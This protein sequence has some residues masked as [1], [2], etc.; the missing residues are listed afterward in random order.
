MD[1]HFESLYE[2]W[3]NEVNI[4]NIT[5]N[6]SEMDDNEAIKLLSVLNYE[7]YLLDNENICLLIFKYLNL[8]DL[9]IVSQVSKRWNH[10][11]GHSILWNNM[12]RIHGSKKECL[13]YINRYLN[14]WNK[15]C[16]CLGVGTLSELYLHTQTT[17]KM[18]SKKGELKKIFQ[19]ACLYEAIDIF[20]DCIQYGYPLSFDD[21]C[22]LINPC[23]IKLE[24][25]MNLVE[26]YHLTITERSVL[27]DRASMS[28][29]PYT[30][31]IF[32]TIPAYRA[33]I[34]KTHLM[35]QIFC[36]NITGTNYL[37]DKFSED[38]I[39]IVLHLLTSNF[40]Y[41]TPKIFELCIDSYLVRNDINETIAENIVKAIVN[42][43]IINTTN[44]EKYL[45]P[46]RKRN[47]NVPNKILGW[48]LS[49]VL[50]NSYLQCTET[51]KENIFRLKILLKY[52]DSNFMEAN[53]TVISSMMLDGMDHSVLKLIEK[54]GDKLPIYRLTIMLIERYLSQSSRSPIEIFYGSKC[55]NILGY[56]K[57][58]EGTTFLYQKW[59]KNVETQMKQKYAFNLAICKAI[60][61]IINY[62]I[63][64]AK[65]Y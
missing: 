22:E 6:Y 13:Q 40:Q 56:V 27:L 47:I 53:E 41:I 63:T 48:Y 44:I 54:N 21:L 60:S 52:M 23:T 38:I 4:Y 2:Q 50:A 58:Y 29:S 7:E 62:I 39:D 49:K 42:S 31:D 30:V 35:N 25:L 61:T 45:L 12:F 65:S 32:R 15:I 33:P 36:G 11:A 34:T 37:I 9:M 17:L 16:S 55:R 18:K 43:S 19:L 57:K 5:N 1:Y 26:C 20:I 64:I 14:Q 28:K 10:I 8:S 24:A 59:I 3:I 46:L 51:L